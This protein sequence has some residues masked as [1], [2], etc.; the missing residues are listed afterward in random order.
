MVL[1]VKRALAM[2]G[3]LTLVAATAP[4][5]AMTVVPAP[6]DALLR[7]ADAV[8]RGVVTATRAEAEDPARPQLWTRVT[9]G[10]VDVASGPHELAVAR[11]L[12]IRLPGGETEAL[13]TV[14]PGVPALVPG[15][16]VIL[17]LVRRGEAWLPLGYSLGTLF[18]DGHERLRRAG[19]DGRPARLVPG[20]SWSSL[21]RG[22]LGPP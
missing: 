2:L 18:V 9:I 22:A 13:R 14:V 20:A 7:E 1:G 21:V 6:L 17:L 19:S 16:E 15:D 8:V 4:G 3:V 10:I 12:E 5:E 11:S